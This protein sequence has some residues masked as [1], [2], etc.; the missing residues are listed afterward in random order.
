M[1][2]VGLYRECSPQ[3][4]NMY[5]GRIFKYLRKHGFEGVASIEL[6]RGAD[7]LPNNCVHFHVLSDDTRSEKELRALFNMAC[8]GAGLCEGDFGVKVYG[9]SD[10]F[11]YFD[12]FTKCGKRYIKKI[13]LF[14]NEKELGARIQ[15]FY[16]LGGWF[17]KSGGKG[18][19]WKAYIREWY[20]K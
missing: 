9:L 10:G 3:E 17:K 4:I 18:R 5:R 1:F 15:K 2:K 8:I 11:G 13:I 12:Y 19:I 16:V 14:R 20:G 7:G 6:T